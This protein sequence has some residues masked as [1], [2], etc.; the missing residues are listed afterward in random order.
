MIGQLAKNTAAN[1]FV[2]STGE[3]IQVMLLS[4]NLTEEAIDRITRRRVACIRYL[5][6]YSDKISLE[7]LPANLEQ[8][9][10]IKVENLYE[11]G[12]FFSSHVVV[13]S[14]IMS[15]ERFRRLVD[16]TMTS[17]SLWSYDTSVRPR[18]EAKELEGQQLGFD[19]A[20]CFV[21]NETT[22]CD[23]RLF[24]IEHPFDEKY[25]NGKIS[26]TKAAS[27]FIS[28]PLD[29][30][31]TIWPAGH[32][33]AYSMFLKSKSLATGEI[34]VCRNPSY[35]KGSLRSLLGR[36]EDLCICKAAGERPTHRN[37]RSCIGEIYSAGQGEGSELYLSTSSGEG[38]TDDSSAKYVGGI[39]FV[40]KP[41]NS[42]PIMCC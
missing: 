23:K 31:L 37:K 32:L 14:D 17:P 41:K 35:N 5:A 8:I 11:P 26:Q 29:D 21:N 40:A 20:G 38:L 22:L 16:A 9:T 7:D 13:G 28:H 36:K 19:I 25:P 4:D 24:L 34:D 12:Y 39:S 3:E 1:K 2:F 15:E 27:E 10:R 18:Y 33:D 6:K 42:E 30:R